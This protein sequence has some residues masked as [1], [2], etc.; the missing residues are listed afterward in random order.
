MAVTIEKHATVGDAQ[1]ALGGD[2]VYLGGGT[3][4][5][6]EINAGFVQGRIIRSTD[7][8]LKQIRQSGDGFE[9]GAGVTMS[10]LANHAE[11]AF[12]HPVVRAI[13]G[14]QIRNMA[15]IGGNL[16]AE[17]P[18]GDLAAALLALG[19]R[20]VMAG[21]QARPIEEFFRDRKRA[22]LITAIQL[23]RPR[24]NKS[25]AF[26]KVSR[27]KPKGVSVMSFSALLPRDAGRLRG[28]R[29]ACIGLG[30][31]PLR[32]FSAERALE[33]QVL[34]AASITRAAQLVTDGLEP[35]TDALASSWYRR[36]VAGVHLTRLLERMI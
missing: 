23:P 9:I 21:G 20:L 7:P 27:V 3:V 17:P 4:L 35:P 36:E 26:H 8:V 34:D 10:A 32:A 16:F 31:G 12:L 19:A 18:Y 30:P 33:G 11:L 1:R 28:V 5:M 29:I 2:A 6:R 15:T 14:P 25:F 24:D 13:G 22:G